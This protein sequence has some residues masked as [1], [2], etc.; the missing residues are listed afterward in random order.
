MQ[1]EESLRV[2]PF[3]QAGKAARKPDI[4]IKNITS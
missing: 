1:K 4:N 3:D 2:S